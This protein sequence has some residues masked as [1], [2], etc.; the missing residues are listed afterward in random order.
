MQDKLQSHTL[1]KRNEHYK[2]AGT[3]VIYGKHMNLG[4]PVEWDFFGKM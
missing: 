2:K 3:S 1:H 4:L